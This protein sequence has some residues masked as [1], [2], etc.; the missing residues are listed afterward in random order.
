MRIRPFLGLAAFLAPARPFLIGIKGE[1][2]ANDWIC[3]TKPQAE[4][5]RGSNGG[6]GVGVGRG[7]QREN[8]SVDGAYCPSVGTGSTAVPDFGDYVYQ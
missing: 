5:G 7:W 6:A 1:K 4:A 3:R 8:R 2:E